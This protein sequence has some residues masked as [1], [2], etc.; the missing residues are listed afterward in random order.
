VEE[1]ETHTSCPGSV[2]AAAGTTTHGGQTPCLPAV[3]WTGPQE[4]RD[5]ILRM[6]EYPVGGP[7]TVGG[8]GW[9][10]RIP[11][12]CSQGDIPDHDW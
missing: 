9:V 11:V 3:C 1:V 6:T 4:V 8:G 7:C 12:C 2:G 10:V 5:S